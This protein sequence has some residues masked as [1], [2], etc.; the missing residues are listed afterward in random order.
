MPEAEGRS[1]LYLLYLLSS[2]LSLSDGLVAPRTP[3]YNPS[4]LF[5]DKFFVRRFHQ[6][7]ACSIK[8]GR[9]RFY[10]KRV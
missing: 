4:P 2:V 1:V 10:K 8:P 7:G 9:R 3:R 5:A 6:S